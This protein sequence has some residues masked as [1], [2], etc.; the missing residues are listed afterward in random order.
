MFRTHHFLMKLARVRGLSAAKSRAVLYSSFWVEDSVPVFI[1]TQAALAACQSVARAQH[2]LG[3]SSGHPLR[4]SLFHSKFHRTPLPVL[5]AARDGDLS[6]ELCRWTG[7]L[8]DPKLGTARR[9][10]TSWRTFLN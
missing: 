5:L 10:E 9:T 1:Q 2:L 3:L 8:M 4:R 7:T 6:S